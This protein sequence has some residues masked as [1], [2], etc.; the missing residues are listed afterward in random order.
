MRL[1]GWVVMLVGLILFLTLMG[2]PTG[3]ES[4][5]GKLGVS[6][7]ATNGDFIANAEASTL[8]NDVFNTGGFLVAL[9]LTV[10]VIVIGLFAKGYDPSL[11]YAGIC[12]MVGFMFIGTFW[13]VMSMVGGYEQ[14][15]LT[16][17][18][19]FIFTTLSFGFIMAL[20][21][22]FGGGR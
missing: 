13:G 3:L 20:I 22:Y 17:I 1:Q 16:A 21:D 4:I 14:W 7:N 10:G 8:W 6:I 2:F 11:I 15:W 9:T 18:I 12:V 19:G 5:V